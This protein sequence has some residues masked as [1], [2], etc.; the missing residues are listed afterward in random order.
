MQMEI[1]KSQIESQGMDSKKNSPEERVHQEDRKRE[2][3]LLKPLK[4]TES[5]QQL[6]LPQSS[7]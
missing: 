3:V 5:N 2:I 7:L 6:L 1:Q 4:A